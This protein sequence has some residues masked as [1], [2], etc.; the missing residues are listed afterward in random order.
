MIN[1]VLLSIIKQKIDEFNLKIQENFE[2]Y[3][4]MNSI[5]EFMFLI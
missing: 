1:L 2:I 5:Y 3:I 4:N